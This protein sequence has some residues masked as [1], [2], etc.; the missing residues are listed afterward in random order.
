MLHA[1][2]HSPHIHKHHSVEFIHVEVDDSLVFRLAS[3]HPGIV[4]ESVYV[5]VEREI[6]SLRAES[7]AYPRS[8]IKTFSLCLT[9]SFTITASPPRYL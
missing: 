8:A 3:Q 5:T 7:P 4:E 6:T 9:K 2:G 1:K